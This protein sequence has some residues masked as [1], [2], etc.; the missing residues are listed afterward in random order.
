M[1]VIKLQSMSYL[2][3]SNLGMIP[4]SSI[5]PFSSVAHLNVSS[6]GFSLPNPN[7]EWGSNTAPAQLKTFCVQR[8][9]LSVLP[10]L[11]AKYSNGSPVVDISDLS[12]LSLELGSNLEEYSA[13][14]LL[15]KLT[16]LHTLDIFSPGAGKL[17]L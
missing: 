9:F 12:L 10:L 5:L 2:T 6:C 14:T 17:H 13:A 4:L 8:S 3:L 15:E 1:R 7:H 11:E 16:S